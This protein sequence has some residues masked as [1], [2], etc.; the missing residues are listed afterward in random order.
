MITEFIAAMRAI[1]KIV[2][3]LNAL[4]DAATVMV[5]SKRREEKDEMVL[6]LIAAARARRE[7]RVLDA[8]TERVSGGDPGG[9]GGV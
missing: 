7:Q 4:T 3:A 8:E 5:A 1:P 6:D 9:P 2:D